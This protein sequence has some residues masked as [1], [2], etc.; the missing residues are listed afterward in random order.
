LRAATAQ[1]V[2]ARISAGGFD[3]GGIQRRAHRLGQ[4]HGVINSPKVQVKQTGLLVE[5]VIVDLDNGDAPLAQ[6]GD[7]GRSTSNTG[8][9]GPSSQAM[10]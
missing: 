5:A 6:G 3:V 4:R 2:V 7:D 10:P 8:A 1:R 9:D